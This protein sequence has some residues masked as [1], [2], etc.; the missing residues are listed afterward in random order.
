MVQHLFMADLIYVGY[1][2]Y[3]WVNSE[4]PPNNNLN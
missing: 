1:T 3:K 2:C 4:I